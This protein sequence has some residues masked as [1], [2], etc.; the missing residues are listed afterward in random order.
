MA[1]NQKLDADRIDGLNFFSAIVR[2]PLLVIGDILGSDGSPR[3]DDIDNGSLDKYDRCTENGAKKVISF[4]DA[5]DDQFNFM[6][7]DCTNRLIQRHQPLNTSEIVT[8]HRYH[9]SRK[10]RTKKMSWSDESGLPLAFEN[11]EVRSETIK[12]MNN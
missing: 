6:G 9:N 4:E 5:F 1:F 2:V 10:K 12:T 11:D 8:N 7:T 3:P